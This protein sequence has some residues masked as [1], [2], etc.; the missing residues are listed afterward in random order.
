MSIG[1]DLRAQLG[2]DVRD[3][4]YF[5]EHYKLVAVAREIQVCARQLR[6]IGL[7]FEIKEQGVRMVGCDLTR[8]RCL[9]NLTR[10]KQGNRR[11]LSQASVNEGEQ[12][13]VKHPC[14]LSDQCTKYKDKSAC[15]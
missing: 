7:T 14:I 13:A 8:E 5:I 2:E 3:N 12:L 10:A 9:A 11:L 1:I 6:T 15:G 4:L